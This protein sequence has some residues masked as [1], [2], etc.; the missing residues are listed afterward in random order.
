MDEVIKGVLQQIGADDW[1]DWVTGE[2]DTLLATAQRWRSAA[3]D[4]Q[5]VVSD[6][7]AERSIVERSWAGEAGEGF[8]KSMRD[9]EDALKGEAE[10]AVTVAELL[11]QAAEACKIAEE[12]M[13]DLL[14]EIVELVLASL[15]TTAILSLLTA[16]AAAA[17]G[18]VVAAAGVATRAAKATRIAGRLATKLDDLVKSTRLLAKASKLRRY[19]RSVDKD[20]I[21][22]WKKARGR[23][24]RDLLHGNAPN[25]S[26][27][28]QYAAVRGAKTVLKGALGVDPSGA[29]TGAAVEGAPGY[30]EERVEYQN[31]PESRTF[32]E[33]TERAER[34]EGQ[35]DFKGKAARDV[36]G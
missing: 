2:S 27:L 4:I 15:A 14:V 8:S 28:A 11:E 33:R 25:T 32:E 35:N 10:D 17:I 3:R 20:T 24:V 16:G 13:Q 7:E 6:L 18:P 29:V 34:T 12:A 23:V 19:L 30:V 9:Y 22:H 26:D 36:F 1:F 31:R 5:D 21:K